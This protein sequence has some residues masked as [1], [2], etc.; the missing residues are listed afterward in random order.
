MYTIEHYPNF[1]E[2]PPDCTWLHDCGF[3]YRPQWFEI[4]QR[5]LFADTDTFRVYA[6]ADAG[7]GR[8]LLLAALRHT[9][10]DSA[11][12]GAD[13]WPRSAIRKT[14]PKRRCC[15]IPQHPTARDC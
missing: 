10:L 1:A 11:A 15:F 14:S 2:L 6:V 13:T 7:S 8:T 4:L 5:S 12:T 9:V 3:F